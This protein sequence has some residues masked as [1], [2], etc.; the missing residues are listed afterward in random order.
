MNGNDSTIGLLAATTTL[1]EMRWR[2]LHELMSL[3]RPPPALSLLAEAVCLVFGLKS[4]GEK[5]YW[6]P[7]LR[8][9]LSDHSAQR[10]FLAFDPKTIPRAAHPRLLEIM[11]EMKVQPSVSCI[12]QPCASLWAWARAVTANLPAAT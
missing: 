5:G 12:S 9:V 3:H 8:L 11:E 6:M 1:S 10:R 7:F 2:D 4:E